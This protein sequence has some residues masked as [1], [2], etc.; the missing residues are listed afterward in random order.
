M[1]L[2]IQLLQLND[3]PYSQQNVVPT[4]RQICDSILLLWRQEPLL[5]NS[6]IETIQGK[7]QEAYPYWQMGG[8]DLEDLML[9]N[10][11]YAV[12]ES[13]LSTFG[14]FITFPTQLPYVNHKNVFVDFCK[15]NGVATKLDRGLFAKKSFQPGD[16]IFQEDKPIVTI[17]PLEKLKLIEM[18]K[19]C[20]SCGHSMNK[21]SQRTILLQN[22]DCND[23]NINWCTANCKKQHQLLHN[24]VT[25]SRR[26]TIPKNWN[27][28]LEY[29]KSN[30]LIPEYSIGI[31]LTFLHLN[32]L[33]AK[34][35][36]TKFNSLCQVSQLD[37]LNFSDSI[38]IGGTLDASNRNYTISENNLNFT[39]DVTE[40]S[41]TNSQDSN[42]FSSDSK[43]TFN[44][45]WDKSLEL[46]L[47]VFPDL[48]EELTKENYL[49]MLGRFNINKI[50][51]QVYYLTSF[52]NHN[53]EPNVRF[54]ILD[55]LQI[56]LFARR[57]IEPNEQ[58]F[59]TYVN[60]L[61]GVKLR[62]RE[63]RV[64]Y[65]FLCHCHRCENELIKYNKVINDLKK[66]AN[67][68]HESFLLATSN[69]E[70][71]RKSSMRNRRPDLQELLKNGK[72][73]ELEIPDEI[74]IGRRRR[75]SVRFS[76]SVS[77]AV[78]E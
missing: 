56:K 77:L 10:N 8:I 66:N 45:Q 47:N 28:F 44:E 27:A 57:K 46:L 76:E 62:R 14:K 64:N 33:L 54:E 23:C 22:L 59:I 61:H 75:T 40:Y 65:G 21:I 60:P 30:L 31:L 72:E 49:N 74:G 16:L 34:D 69:S 17:P 41:D 7:L 63:L 58:L 25:H 78:E 35:I 36:R 5:E 32:K 53:C 18:G 11:L 12:D 51:N 26:S 4:E 38:N 39:V 29:C 67:T 50:S 24:L 43:F 42:N 1:P 37:R 71:R 70:K 20:A 6:S 68:N 13:K 73:F 52:I 2:R 3:L 55:N 15:L 48:E 19:C 9:R